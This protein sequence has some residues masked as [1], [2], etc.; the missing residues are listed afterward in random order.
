[1]TKKVRIPTL[2]LLAVMWL[3]ATIIGLSRSLISVLGRKNILRERIEELTRLKNANEELKKKLAEVQAPEFV[4]R[5]ARNKLNLSKEGETVIL[6][7]QTESTSNTPAS[8]TPLSS[9]NWKKWWHL[10]F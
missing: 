4:E 5:E 7:D 8:L 1:M 2:R 6:V 9:S 10:F 3:L